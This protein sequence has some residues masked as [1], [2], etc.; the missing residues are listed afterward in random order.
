MAWRW[1]RGANA[2]AREYIHGSVSCH[3]DLPRREGRCK[4]SWRDRLTGLNASVGEQLGIFPRGVSLAG[5][6]AAG[7]IFQVSIFF[8]HGWNPK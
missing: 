5:G 8:S 4:G 2:K 3:V 6:G 1:R 7:E